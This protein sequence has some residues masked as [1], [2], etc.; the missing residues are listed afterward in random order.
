VLKQ[1][2]SI[3]VNELQPLKREP[4]SVNSLF[5]KKGKSNEVKALQF[6]N[7]FVI[8][9]TSDALKFDRFNDSN[10]SHRANIFLIVVTLDVSK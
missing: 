1:D 3:D 7:I 6:K 10:F 5:S 2:K 8:D 9:L 4:I